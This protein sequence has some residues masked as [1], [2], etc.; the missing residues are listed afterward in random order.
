MRRVLV[1][2]AGGMV[3]RELVRRLLMETE[4]HLELLIRPIHGLAV[5]DYL[6]DVVEIE[7][8][9]FKSRVTVLGGDC[10]QDRLGL[11]DDAIGRLRRETSHI[12]HAAAITRFDLP[13]ERA[14]Q[15]N[16]A[17]VARV[18]DLAKSC[19][20]LER[21]FFVSTVYV[22]GRRTGIIL[23][24]DRTQPDGFVNTYERSKYEGEALVAAAAGEVPS[25]VFRLSTLFGDARSGR[26]GHFTAPHQALR[27]IY[28]GLASMLPG[29]PACRVDLIPVDYAVGAMAALLDSARPGETFHLAAGA[30]R[31]FTLQEIVD[32]S[33][34][35][36]GERDPSWRAR[37]YPK[38][39]FSTLEVFD[40]YVASVRQAN[41]V[42]LA[43]VLGALEHFVGQLAYPKEFD[44]ST[45]LEH[46]PDYDRKMPHIREYFARVVDYCLETEWGRRVHGARARAH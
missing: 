7:P 3:G 19:A 45:V 6:R 22:A 18:L 8:A 30:D 16:T 13:L 27:I 43:R 21:F 39:T 4:D 5:E 41:N 10:T 32:A 14:R 36:L 17:T 25:V 24:R 46:L 11:P 15:L 2:G 29:D 33:H 35:A 28:S 34:E 31:S 1:T 40:L 44:R 12:V 20:R 37:A 9:R 23:E 38:P 26:V 42:L